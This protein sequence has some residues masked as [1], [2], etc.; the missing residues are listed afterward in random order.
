MA[1]LQEII[2]NELQEQRVDLLNSLNKLNFS[3]REE[4][5]NWIEGMIFGESDLLDESLRSLNLTSEDIEINIF[6]DFQHET[7]EKFIEAY[8]DK[9]KV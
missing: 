2:L 5:R 3:E 4:C 6:R 8:H 7:V 1:D 9:N